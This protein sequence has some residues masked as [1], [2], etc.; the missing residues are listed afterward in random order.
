MRAVIAEHVWQEHR[1]RPHALMARVP[2]EGVVVEDI[3]AKGRT[4][5][6]L[7]AAALCALLTLPVL[8][9]AARAAF[10]TTPTQVFMAGE[11]ERL[12]LNT[13]AHVWSGGAK[14]VGGPKLIPPPHP[15]ARFPGQP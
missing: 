1:S 9:T 2:T 6:R 14:V 8:A 15:I 7:A 5:R 13:P 3:K 12:S 10:F 4:I 11:I